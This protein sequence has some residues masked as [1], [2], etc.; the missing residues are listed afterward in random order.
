MFYIVLCYIFIG[1]YQLQQ[2]YSIIVLNM[3]NQKSD[4]VAD[5]KIYFRA[6]SKYAKI[7]SL[8]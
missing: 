4:S 8:P 1:C 6:S 3:S 7:V 5:I 2:I